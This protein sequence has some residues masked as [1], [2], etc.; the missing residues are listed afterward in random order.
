M[1]YTATAHVIRKHFNVFYKSHTFANNNHK[2]QPLKDL[3]L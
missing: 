1:S 2:S 3:L